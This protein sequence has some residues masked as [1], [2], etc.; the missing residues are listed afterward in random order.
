MLVTPQLMD[1]PVFGKHYQVQCKSCDW[2]VFV[3]DGTPIEQPT[4]LTCEEK[5]G[6]AIVKS[7][8]KILVL[9]H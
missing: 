9:A 6:K 8:D 1:D 5:S 7:G 2:W 3:L 4:C